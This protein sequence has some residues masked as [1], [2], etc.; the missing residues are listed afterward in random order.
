MIVYR[1][2]IDGVSTLLETEHIIV[3]YGAG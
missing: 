2:T 3:M 1:P